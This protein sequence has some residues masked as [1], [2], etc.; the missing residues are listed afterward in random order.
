MASGRRLLAP[1]R[2]SSVG[3][4][5]GNGTFCF[6]TVAVPKSLSVTEGTNASIQ[7][8]QIAETGS[9]LYN[10]AD[11][12]F[13]SDAK[14]LGNNICANSTGVGGV[15]LTSGTSTLESASSTTPKA[16]STTSS[17]PSIG[18]RD[19]SAMTLNS[20]AVWIAVA[21]LG[22]AQLARAFL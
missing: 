6:P 8:I 3:F 22:L 4:Y 13:S 1:E 2:S 15:R 10:C 19:I 16:A 14:I 11:I 7:V 20:P 18:A 17:K 9:S 21:A 5:T 12:T